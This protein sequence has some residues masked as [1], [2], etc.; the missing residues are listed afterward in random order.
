MCSTTK[1][2]AVMNEQVKDE[3]LERLKEIYKQLP[4]RK[5]EILLFYGEGLAADNDRTDEAG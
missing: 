3:K 1:G 5:Q 4:P 2:G